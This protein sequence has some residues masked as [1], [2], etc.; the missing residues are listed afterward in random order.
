MATSSRHPHP[1]PL[2][3]RGRGLV[4][5]FAAFLAAPALAAPVQAAHLQAELVAQDASATPGSTVYVALR[6]KIEPGW[7][8]YWRNS[9]DSGQPTT[10]TWTLPK[11]WKAGE[12]VWPTPQRLRTGPLMDYGYSGEVLLPVPLQVPSDAPVGG[13]VT[14]QAKAAFLVCKDVCVPAD[15][16]LSLDLPVAAGAPK[17]DSHGGGK[18]AK[19]L[20]DAPKPA[21]LNA[22]MTAQAD[23]V[24][25]SVTGAPLAGADLSDAY[26]YPFDATWVDHAKPQ[27]VERG[28]Q[29][30]TLSL[31]PGE[32][33]KTGKPPASLNGVLALGDK[34]FEVDAPS[35]PVLAGATGLGA[36]VA[37]PKTDA[38][39]LP[40]A[41]VFAFLGGLILNLMPCV[42]PVLSMKAA[43]LAGHGHE[44]RAARAQ[45]LVF[46]AGV[47]STFLALA[48]L[49]IAAKAAGQAVGWGFQLQSPGVVGA[50]FLVMLLVALN[51][52]GVFEVGTSVQ[53][54][55]TGLASRRGLAG[56]FF[57]GAL[58]VVVAAPCTAPF[59]AGAIGYA[60]TLHPAAALSVF[61]A[62][63]LGLAA[64]FTALSF[65][66]GLLRR[67][68]KPGGW[69]D[70][71]KSVLAFPMYAAAAWLAWVLVLQAGP[72]AMLRL[73]AA[74]ILAAFSAWLYGAAQQ[75]GWSG[76]TKLVTNLIAALAFAGAVAGALTIKTAPPAKG[77]SEAVSAAEPPSQPYTAQRL[78]DLRAQGKPAFVN[79]TAA[80]CVTCQVNGRV[81]LA[82]R[83]VNDAFKQAGITYL[84][85]DWTTRDAE[86]ARA[87][88]EHG[89][90]GVPL[91]LMYGKGGREAVVLPQL[92]T[93]GLVAKA[94]RD[95]AKP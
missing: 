2:P 10:I 73:S 84:V 57:T 49:L 45:G 34:A 40:L 12:I 21:G 83:E 15:A 44:P 7:H 52:S 79:F 17:P 59:M 39:G 25:L 46:A 51:L 36:P 72:E 93:A 64:P 61:A 13:K 37:T 1:Q 4:F 80:W 35:G 70:I 71:L 92:L 42:F 22:A 65:A 90:A 47:V 54:A 9:G 85:A 95:A 86:I 67:L 53:G 43:A 11:G 82:T 94:A 38:L 91:Y 69:M 27:P 3:A 33:F 68:P 63:G 31:V 5:A 28:Q 87:L 20:A 24:K 6:Q 58:A 75:R 41:I 30:L 16:A 14:L 78:A 77:A 29:G 60:L 74:A 48:A 81:A 18:V 19:T 88:T 26:F 62:L 32:A 55:G 50:L 66:P 23:A 76:G 8:T 56:A 89:R